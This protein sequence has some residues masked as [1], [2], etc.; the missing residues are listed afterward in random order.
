MRSTRRFGVRRKV[1]VTGGA[2][3][4]GSSLAAQLLD[5]GHE[6]VVLDNML[7]GR[8]SYL[9]DSR[10]L[11]LVQGDIR[12][13]TDLDKAFSYAPDAVIHLAAQHFIPYCN[14]N[15]D[16][17]IHVNVYGTQRV[18]DAV[19][20]HGGVAKL[21]FASTAAIYAPSDTPHNEAE[22]PGPI[23]IYGVSK[24]QGEQLIDFFH[25]QTGVAA[26]NARLF[27]VVGPRETNPHLVP[28]ILDQLPSDGTLRLGNLVPKRDYI[29]ADDV[30][31]AL[32][33][34]M[35]S[36]ISSGSVNI[37]SGR[38]FSASDIVEAI[39]NVLGVELSIDSVPERQRAGD[40]PNLCSDN[41]K[42]VDLGWQ[43]QYDLTSALR[44]T[45]EFY[46]KL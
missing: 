34:I 10:Q 6:V 15:P 37:G 46:D 23:D 32:L 28:D 24:V 42:L 30:A 29:H 26:V 4:I 25:R 45:L 18:I 3:F 17:T 1:L 5:N 44:S 12:S 8:D 35:E 9:P 31:S 7:R 22:S 20:R 36:D 38:S 21:I 11:N 43:A 14:D 33:T 16:D 19:S 39:A 40:R 13:D 2:G 27:N 41:K